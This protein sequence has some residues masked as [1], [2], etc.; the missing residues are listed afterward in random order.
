M[1]GERMRLDPGRACL[2]GYEG[3]CESLLSTVGPGGQH[4][5]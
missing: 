1:V 4:G 3:E 2:V 5:E